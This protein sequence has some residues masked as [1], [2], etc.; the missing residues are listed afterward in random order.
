MTRVEGQIKIFEDIKDMYLRNGSITNDDIYKII[1]EFGFTDEE[2][3]MR[4]KKGLFNF[5]GTVKTRGLISNNEE[6]SFIP[7]S[8]NADTSKEELETAVKMYISVDSSSLNYAY[9]D[10][11]NYLN[12]NSIKNNSKARNRVT[13]DDIVIRLPNF[14]DVET[15]RN[16]I[17]S[18]PK[19]KGSIKKPN[20]FLP[21][22]DMG[23]C[24]S[25]DGRST[26]V[27]NEL[28]ISLHNFFEKSKNDLNSFNRDNFKKYLHNTKSEFYNKYPTSLFYPESVRI[29]ALIEL[30][31]DEDF[32]FE[33]MKKYATL[34][35]TTKEDLKRMTINDLIKMTCRD[36]KQ[37][38]PKS[39]PLSLIPYIENL[40][41]EDFNSSAMY[42]LSKVFLT[43][44]IVMDYLLKDMMN[45]QNTNNKKFV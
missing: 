16:Y 31:M 8:S 5:K 7:F 29:N 2:K 15:V 1:T 11:N 44:D 14:R 4:V 40:K 20:P 37:K 19:L 25:M 23:I 39:E 6:I 33:Q 36:L 9:R 3:Q 27:N 26:S 43:K 17:R 38:Y 41:E 13:N 45:G 10:L 21:Q 12:S 30:S 18:N 24:Y 35:Q 34:I 28:S 42:H 22:D 32:D